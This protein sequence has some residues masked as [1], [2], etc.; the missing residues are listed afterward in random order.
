M[1]VDCTFVPAADVKVSVGLGHEVVQLTVSGGTHATP[2]A[3]MVK[4]TVCPGVNPVTVKFDGE[5]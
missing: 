5:I 1:H 2:F 4:T 3:V